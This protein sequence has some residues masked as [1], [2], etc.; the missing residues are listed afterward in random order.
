M[1][2]FI[3]EL[4]QNTTVVQTKYA[5]Q[6]SKDFEI[7]CETLPLIT[8]FI[9]IMS[10]ADKRRSLSVTGMNSLQPPYTPADQ[11]WHKNLS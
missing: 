10:R 3:K 11:L 6:Y 5:G 7:F 4:P 8:I 2:N 9:V 1:I